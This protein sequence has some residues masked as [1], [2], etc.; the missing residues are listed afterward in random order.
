[1]NE[2]CACW[3]NTQIDQECNWLV[4]TE[5]PINKQIGGKPVRIVFFLYVRVKMHADL[6]WLQ[7][8]FV[9]IVIDPNACC[10]NMLCGYLNSIKNSFDFQ[11]KHSKC[12]DFNSS[13][14]H[15]VIFMGVSE[16]LRGRRAMMRSLY[17]NITIWLMNLF[18]FLNRLFE[19]CN[20]KIRITTTTTTEQTTKK[21]AW[22]YKYILLVCFDL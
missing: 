5:K 21:V 6:S 17:H 1:M 4:T 20:A 3:Q 10:V 12:L 11:Y 15:T 16:S 7:G 14:Y 8:N 18:S 19:T 13:Y 2:W 22:S 9:L